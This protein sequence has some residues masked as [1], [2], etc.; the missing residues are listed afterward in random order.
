IMKALRNYDWPA[1]RVEVDGEEITRSA[2]LVVIANIKSY[3][4]ME[5]AEKAALN[6][7]LLDI[8]VFQTRSWGAMFRYALGAFTKTHTNDRDV[9]YVQGKKIKLSAD[10]PNVPVQMDGDNAGVLP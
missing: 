9:I 7:G 2:G 8:C 4:V 6:D 10:R 1:I 5:V 3:A